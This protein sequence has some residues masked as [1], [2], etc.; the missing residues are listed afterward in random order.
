MSC[1][2]GPLD[3]IV[4]GYPIC[5]STNSIYFLQ[6]SGRSSYFLI[7]RMSHF[8]PGSFL[9]TGFAFSNR[10]VVGNSVVTSPSISYPTHTG[11]SSRY[12]STSNTV[13][14]TSV[15]PCIL[16]PYLEATQSNH[17]I[18][19]GRPVVAPNSPPSPPRRLNSSASSPKI[20]LTN[21]PAPTALEYALHTVTIFLI[22]YGGIPAPIA[23]YRCQCRR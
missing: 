14:A 9:R 17:P 19:L 5:S 16:H 23:P 1:L 3:T 22:S 10:C 2:S 4:I 18:L 20:S 12:P 21:A 7:P 13:N 15:A 6:F 8:H 11:I